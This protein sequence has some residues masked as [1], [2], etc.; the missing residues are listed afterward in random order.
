MPLETRYITV[1][2]VV[3]GNGETDLLAAAL[4]ARDYLLQKHE[5]NDGNR[6]CLNISCP[7]DFDGP[8]PCILKYC[9]DLEAMDTGAR[10]QL[11][12]ANVREFSIG[13]EAGEQPSCLE[14]H[15]QPETLARVT[16]LGAG[17]GIV[18]Y[19][20]RSQDPEL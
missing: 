3:K 8:E 13:Y 4:G 18:L 9:E 5:W 7:R 14:Q 20:A 16:G 12:Q 10:T 19:P 2:L 1:D 15:L 6:W 17:V 11:A